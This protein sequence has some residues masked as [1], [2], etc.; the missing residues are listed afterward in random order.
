MK[1]MAITGTGRNSGKTTTVESV[2]KSLS[3]KGLRVGTIKQIHEDSFSIDTPDKDTWRHAEAGAKIVVTAAPKEVALIRRI[4]GERFSHAWRLISGEDLDVVIV[5]GNP[6]EEVPRILASNAPEPAEERMRVLND[7]FCVTS[8]SPEKFD[9]G[10]PVP[11]L[12]PLKN[13]RK[14]LEIVETRILK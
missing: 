9:S 12:H 4:N 13:A 8:L 7:V 1:V 11:V 3:S 6:P 2:V 14:L 5:E 10:F